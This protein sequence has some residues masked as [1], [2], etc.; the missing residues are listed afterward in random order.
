M[1]LKVDTTDEIGGEIIVPSSKSHTIRGFVFASL[2]EGESRLVNALEASDTQAA[3]NACKALGAGIE[4]KNGEFIIRG[5]SGKPKTDIK[6]DTLNSGTTTNLIMGTSALGDKKVIIDGDASIRKRTV[7]PLLDALNALGAKAVSVNSNGCPPVEITGRI[8]GGKVDVDCRSSQYVSSLL[9]NCPL[10]SQD[11]EISILNLCEQPYIEMTLRWLDE[12]GI[13]YENNDLKTIRIFGNQG[14]KG[15]EK[16]IP[17]D[18][19]SATFLLVAGVMLGRNLIIKGLDIK[20]TQADKEVLDYLRKMGADIRIG[21]EGIVINKSILTGCELD[22]NNTP[23][24]LPAISVLGCYAQGKTVIKNVGHARI[25][26]TDRIVVM[27]EELSRMGANIEERQDGVVIEHSELNGS[28]VNGYHDHR[29]VM[30]L[31]LAGMIASGRTVI[32]TAEAV[33]V[34]FPNYADIMKR[35][36]AKIEIIE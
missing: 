31:S 13:R 10:A 32:D 15:F 14:Y 33:S 16:T 28:H 8:K 6:I 20:D 5:F 26:E 24:A 7:Q 21:K 22:L 36:G 23:D 25:K 9:I 11:T 1:K 27:T 34:T 29:V 2:A 35:I 3:I 12:R 4:K 17:G 30:A 18:W 19:S